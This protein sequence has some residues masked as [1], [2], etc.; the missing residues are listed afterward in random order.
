MKKYLAYKPKESVT[1]ESMR[2]ATWVIAFVLGGC[3]SPPAGLSISPAEQPD[4]APP[5][6]Q[7]SPEAGTPDGGRDAER[8]LVERV[9]AAL[10]ACNEISVGKFKSDAVSTRLDLE[11][12]GTMGGIHFRAD[13]DIDCDGKVTT[14]CNRMTDSSFLP[15]TAGVE[16]NGEPLDSSIVP[17]VVVPG[18]SSRFDYRMRGV[19]MGSL[20]VVIYDGKLAYGTVGDVGPVAILGEASYAMAKVL[21]INPD[22]SRGGTAKEVTYLIFTGPE[23]EVAKLEDLNEA[24]TKGAAALQAWLARNPP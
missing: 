2:S 21:G 20:A 14:V 23:N 13:M 10:Q 8:P 3:A 7:A 15:R 24:Q 4:A 18:V 6:A 11:V 12:C 5:P 19:A 9:M 1:V 16:S 22:P 17:Y